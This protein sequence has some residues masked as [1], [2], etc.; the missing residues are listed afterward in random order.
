MIISDSSG[1]SPAASPPDANT[2]DERSEHTER[3]AEEAPARG[4]EPGSRPV[5]PSGS[6][7]TRAPLLRPL[8]P[9]PLLETQPC[10]PWSRGLGCSAW[11]SRVGWLF[12]SLPQGPLLLPDVPLLRPSCLTSRSWFFVALASSSDHPACPSSP[13]LP[14]QNQRAGWRPA[15]LPHRDLKT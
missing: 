11:G 5:A 3:D 8:Q 1:N 9:R 2:Q 7:P 10:P 12:S 15:A 6:L 13:S 14:C 4:P